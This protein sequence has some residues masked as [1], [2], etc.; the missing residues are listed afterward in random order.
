MKECYKVIINEGQG[1]EPKVKAFES[2]TNAW[3]E[4]YDIACVTDFIVELYDCNNDCI[5]ACS[6]H[7]ALES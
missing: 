6:N 4:W 7:G 3:R 1:I 2:E 5:I